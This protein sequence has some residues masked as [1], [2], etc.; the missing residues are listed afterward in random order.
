VLADFKACR[1]QVMVATDVAARGI[2]IARLPAVV[3]YDL[4]RSAVD[5]THRIA[6]PGV[7]AR[8]AWPSASSAQRRNSICG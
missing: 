8:A 6:A 5:Y 3:N 2:D 1:L 7:P 4:P